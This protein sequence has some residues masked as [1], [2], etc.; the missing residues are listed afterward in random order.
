MSCDRIVISRVQDSD[1][2]E[3]TSILLS[4]ND[5]ITYVFFDYF[6]DIKHV[7]QCLIDFLY[8]TSL[9]SHSKY[10]KIFAGHS[11]PWFKKKY[12]LD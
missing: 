2:E 10:R 3:S 1:L 11:V 6:K 12:I 7:T 8:K 4:F 9:L 5:S